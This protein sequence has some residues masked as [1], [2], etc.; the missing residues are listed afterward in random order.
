MNVRALTMLL[1]VGMAGSVGLMLVIL[2]GFLDDAA[3]RA[4]YGVIAWLRGLR[5]FF[6]QSPLRCARVSRSD[7]VLN[8]NSKS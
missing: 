6:V 5:R 2:A 1:A 4:R 7:K 8:V 3:G